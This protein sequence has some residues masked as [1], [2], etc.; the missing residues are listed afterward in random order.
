LHCGKL[1]L[2]PFEGPAFH[3]FPAFIFVAFLPRLVAILAESIASAALVSNVDLIAHVDFTRFGHQQISI[4]KFPPVSRGQSIFGMEPF[5]LGC[6]YVAKRSA[7]RDV[8]DL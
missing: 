5:F 3:A 4:S 6:R 7:F 8:V 1:S 2:E